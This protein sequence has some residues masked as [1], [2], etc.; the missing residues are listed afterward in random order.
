MPAGDVER[1]EAA[2]GDLLEELGYS[3]ACLRPQPEMLESV[4]R[5]RN[6]LS[7]DPVWI[8]DSRQR[9]VTDVNE[10]TSSTA[11]G[12]GDASVQG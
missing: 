9:G 11:I 3:R 6:L 10:V 8:H 7:Q 12:S 2:A 4:S 5:I 1:F